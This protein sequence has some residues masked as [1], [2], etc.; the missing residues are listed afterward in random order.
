MRDLL[1]GENS[2]AVDRVHRFIRA[3]GKILWVEGNPSIVLGADGEVAG[4]VNVFRDVTRRRL[5][6]IAQVNGEARYRAIA[7]RTADIIAMSDNDGR[8]IFTSP[9]TRWSWPGDSRKP[10]PAERNPRGNQP[11][12]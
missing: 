7:E 10:R 11:A 9:S 8:I 12:R 6:E 2:T 1:S 5:A 3:D 4:M